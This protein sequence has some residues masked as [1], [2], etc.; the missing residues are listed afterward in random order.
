MPT[1]ATLL[2]AHVANSHIS[3]MYEYLQSYRSITSRTLK[4][5]C[6]LSY[7]MPSKFKRCHLHFCLGYFII[8]NF[9]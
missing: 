9:L 1:T 6:F 4:Y 3:D 8:W 5:L 7:T 2:V